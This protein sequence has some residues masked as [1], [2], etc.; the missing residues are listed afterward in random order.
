MII[1]GQ[2]VQIIAS[3]SGTGK[4][5][6]AKQNKNFVDIDRE[7]MFCK[8]P[9]LPRDINETQ[10]EKLKGESHKKSKDYPENF[11]KLF[12]KMID[13]GKNLL[14]VPEPFI[15]GIISGHN[16]P[17]VL[18][19]PSIECKKEYSKRMLNRGNSRE[20][21]GWFSDYY[22]KYYLDNENDMMAVKKIKLMP[23]QYLSDIIETLDKDL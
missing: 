11:I 21:A 17:Y 9:D 19:Y 3:T 2:N 16:L 22:D 13:E 5:T 23:G 15:M 4:T 20:F 18:V 12:F 1:N 6:L 14:V 8:Y 7:K 10:I